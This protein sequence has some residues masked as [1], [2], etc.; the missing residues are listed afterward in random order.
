MNKTY[1][2][3]GI[4]AVALLGVYMY[5]RSRNTPTTAPSG[6]KSGDSEE[7]Q[8]QTSET[9]EETKSE[10]KETKSI[11]RR[12][13]PLSSPT[14]PRTT[15]STS[16]RVP[17]G[18]MPNYSN[19]SNLGKPSEALAQA[20]KDASQ[21]PSTIQLSGASMNC[22][23][24]AIKKFGINWRTTAN[25]YIRNQNIAWFE[26]CK[27]GQLGVAPK[28]NFLPFYSVEEETFAFNGHTF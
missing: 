17:S 7:T 9:T 11:P 2:Y 18:I 28:Q 21:T 10:P 15:P 20:M 3:I 24:E 1:L 23:A 4:G 16:P 5:A 25:S 26:K 12:G 13:K 22:E 14:T 8:T 27:Q 6:S 19:N